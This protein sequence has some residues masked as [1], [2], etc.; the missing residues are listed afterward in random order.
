MA[1]EGVANSSSQQALIHATGTH[2]AATIVRSMGDVVHCVPP[3]LL[4]ATPTQHMH[5]PA[6]TAHNPCVPHPALNEQRW[7]LSP[8]HW[9]MRECRRG[10]RDVLHTCFSTGRSSPERDRNG[11]AAAPFIIPVLPVSTRPNR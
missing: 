2:P 4:P 3:P 5:T 1:G 6:D 9:T 8:C 7:S 10:L 11:T